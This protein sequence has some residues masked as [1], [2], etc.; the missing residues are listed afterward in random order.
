MLWQMAVLIEPK[1]LLWEDVGRY[2][3]NLWFRN[4]SSQQLNY[5]DF[6]K[7]DYIK[8]YEEKALNNL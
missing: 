3:F 6:D 4:I 2:F 7:I 8:G 5:L 1:K